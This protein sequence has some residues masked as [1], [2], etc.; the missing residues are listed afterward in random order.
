MRD[1]FGSGSATC[2][3][4]VAI[5][6]FS[7]E[8]RWLAPLK[9]W[10]LDEYF[11]LW[12]TDPSNSFMQA[13]ANSFRDTTPPLYYTALFWF[14]RL[15]ENERYAVLCL[16]L[17]A[18]AVALI[19]VCLASRKSATVGVGTGR[20]G[21]LPVQR[22]GSGH[23]HGGAHLPYGIG[24]YLSGFLVLRPRRSRCRTAVPA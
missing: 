19:A 7:Y 5:A 21:R 15:I 12:S 17:F 13:I 11:S 16:N 10:W 23:G 1:R 3:L 24:R 2:L 14:R 6:V 18:L 20:V 9:G 4:V 8:F 22:P